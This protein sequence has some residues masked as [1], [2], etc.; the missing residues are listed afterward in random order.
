MRPEIRA[1]YFQPLFVPFGGLAG[2]RHRQP[3]YRCVALL[4]VALQK[5][6]KL[7]FIDWFDIQQF[8]DFCEKA[9]IHLIQAFK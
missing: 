2:K 9:V 4:F 6:H 1:Q 5:F 3:N 8:V 7:R